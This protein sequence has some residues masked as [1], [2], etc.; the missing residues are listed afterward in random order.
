MVLPIPSMVP[1]ASDDHCSPDPGSPDSDAQQPASHFNCSS[2][3]SLALARGAINRV[4]IATKIK[5]QRMNFPWD[6]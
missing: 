4:N 3:D 5:L 1:P 6:R 2:C